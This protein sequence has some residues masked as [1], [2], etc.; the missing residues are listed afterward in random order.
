[1]RQIKVACSSAQRSTYV[2]LWSPVCSIVCSIALPFCTDSPTLIRDAISLEKCKAS[3]TQTFVRSALGG[4][5]R[6]RGEG[7]GVDIDICYPVK[8]AILHT[9]P[10]NQ[11]PFLL[12]SIDARPIISGPCIFW[13]FLIVEQDQGG[14]MVPLCTISSTKFRAFSFLGSGLALCTVQ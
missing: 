9:T 4:V 11:S 13:S 10:T 6:R 14:S 1:M 7:T 3:R 2:V 12:D 8:G 5:D